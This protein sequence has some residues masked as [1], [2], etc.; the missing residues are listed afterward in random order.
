[1]PVGVDQPLHLGRAVQ[2]Q[3]RIAV[4]V[5]SSPAVEPSLPPKPLPVSTSGSSA[6]GQ[7]LA[8]LDPPLVE[9]L[10]PQITP[11]TNTRCS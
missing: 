9:Q 6:V 11:S 5:S 4:T 2:H 10:M 7:L 8:E 3:A 1:M